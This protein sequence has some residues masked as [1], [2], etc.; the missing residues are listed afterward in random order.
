M[1]YNDPKL[2]KNVEPKGVETSRQ[3]PADS[4]SNAPEPTVEK[5]SSEIKEPDNSIESLSIQKM[6][7][8]WYSL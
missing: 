5:K 2:Y 4:A 7:E 6:K 8:F 1:L 3:S